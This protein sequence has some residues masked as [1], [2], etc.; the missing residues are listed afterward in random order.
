MRREWPP[1]RLDL[2][3]KGLLERE[4]FYCYGRCFYLFNLLQI[5]GH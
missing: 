3:L 2:I 4:C 5:G 1:L